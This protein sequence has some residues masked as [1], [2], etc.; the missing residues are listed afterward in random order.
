MVKDVWFGR[1]AV[2]P[3]K[4]QGWPWCGCRGA[5]PLLGYGVK[6]RL[7]DVLSAKIAPV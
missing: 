4:V 6:P 5:E 3:S 7:L 2:E 1:I